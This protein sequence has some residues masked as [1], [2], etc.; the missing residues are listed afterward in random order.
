MELDT[1]PVATG[2]KT[3]RNLRHGAKANFISLNVAKDSHVTV[4]GW[5]RLTA[6][7]QKTLSSVVH[8]L[9]RIGPCC[10]NRKCCNDP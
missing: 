6:C 10:S 5:G 9:Q 1:R 3:G 8:R 7:V 4:E 2:V